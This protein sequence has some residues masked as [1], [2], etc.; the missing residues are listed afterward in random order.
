[1]ARTTQPLVPSNQRE[2]LNIYTVD[3]LK[4]IARQMKFGNTI[5]SK[6]ADY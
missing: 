3:E 5:P 1:M 2:A 4:D 6:K